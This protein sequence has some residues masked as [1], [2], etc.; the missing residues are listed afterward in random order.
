MNRTEIVA[1]LGAATEAQMI[2][3]AK[4]LPAE[5]DL[6]EARLDRLADPRQADLAALARGLGRP[7]IA[8]LRPAAEGGSFH[9]T[10]EERAALLAAAE[11][12]GFPW[13]DLEAD[14]AE[15]VPRGGARRIVSW[16]GTEPTNVSGAAAIDGLVRFDADVLKVACTAASAAAALDFVDGALARGRALGRPVVALAMGRPGRFLRPLAVP[17]GAPFLYTAA[18]S[19]RKTA[20]GQLSVAEALRIVGGRPLTPEARVYAVAG[21]DVAASLSPAAHNAAFRAR[22]L[23]ALYVDL[24]ADTFEDVLAVARRLP[25]AGLSVTA[26]FK[27]DARAAASAATAAAEAS[28][29]ANTLL[30]DAGGAWHADDTDGD[31]FLSAL[32]LA[33][34]EPDTALDLC[35]HRATDALLH[36]DARRFGT[37]RAPLDTALV[38]GTGGAARA[39]AAALRRAGVRVSITGR[40]LG[41]AVALA[42]AL[43]GVEAISPERA[44]SRKFDLLV[45]AIPG[46]DGADLALDPFE[47]QRK[48]FAADVVYRP[49]E[50]PFLLAA[51]MAG[52]VPVSGLLMF[53]AQAMLQAATF[54][55]TEV[56]EVRDAVAHGI[57]SALA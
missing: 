33:L 26:P 20:G 27:A 13:I 30:R 14:L 49:I 22:G 38:Y 18:H 12:A 6:V 16:H 4:R 7:A 17:K 44:N 32:A 40:D 56:H 3:D 47:F 57:E 5:V 8:T 42:V 46:I 37:E 35:V 52:R 10:V 15:R 31:G 1:A 39:I 29:A 24:S 28:G 54:T 11:R 55:G 25:L 51:R 45:R 19:S 21:A 41:R 36:L 9:G 23:D 43:G 53:A 34:A 50:T 48:G 2:E